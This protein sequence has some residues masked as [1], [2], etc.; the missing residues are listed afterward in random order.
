[1]PGSAWP[2]RWTRRCAAS[3]AT[4]WTCRS[5]GPTPGLT[6][7]L[8]GDPPFWCPGPD[9]ALVRWQVARPLGDGRDPYTTSTSWE[10]DALLLPGLLG[11]SGPATTGWLGSRHRSAAAITRT[12]PPLLRPEVID[13]IVAFAGSLAGAAPVDPIEI[14]LV[15]P[16]G[17][18]RTCLAAAAAARLGLG[19]VSVDART[20]AEAADPRSRRGPGD[21]PGPAGRLRGRMAARRGTARGPPGRSCR[22]AH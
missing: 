13:A 19:L 6:A 16:P 17:S 20:L 22:S 5:R 1:M 7:E 15:G 4:C 10:A 21:P 9:S 8:F 3:S 18:G 11:P 2:R 12:R 14:E